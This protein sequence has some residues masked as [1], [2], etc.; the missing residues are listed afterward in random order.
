M[1]EI[2]W[3]QDGDFI[4]IKSD[5]FDKESCASSSFSLGKGE[6]ASFALQPSQPRQSLVHA[7]GCT[8]KSIIL[9]ELNNI[10]PDGEI[11]IFEKKLAGYS[12]ISKIAC[13]R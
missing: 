11:R 3:I 6:T 4:K 12:Y 9:E 13:T 2:I 10:S 5:V 1:D 7:R 8:L